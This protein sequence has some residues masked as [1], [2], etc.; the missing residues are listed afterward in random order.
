MIIHFKVEAST[1]LGFGHLRRCEVLAAA[2]AGKGVQCVFLQPDDDAASCENIIVDLFHRDNQENPV[3]LATFLKTLRG[4]AVFIDG[5][6]D[7]A[8]RDQAAPRLLAYV[9]PYPGAEEDAPPNAQHWIKGGQYAILGPQFSGLPPKKIVPRAKNLLLAFGGADPQ[10]LTARVM[11]ALAGT[12]FDIR[13]ILGP[14]F[15]E[16]HKKRI[17]AIGGAFTLIE[18]AADLLPHYLWADIAAGSSG[19]TRFE[20]AA[21]GVP[22]VF[23][24]LYPHHARLSEVYAQSGA[25]QYLGL[26]DKLDAKAWRGALCDL[27]VNE[28]ARKAMSIAGQRLVD[29]RGT[30]RLAEEIL[31]LFNA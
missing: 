21:C 14:L 28:A 4:K 16:A 6:F 23:A 3:A 8:F 24:A 30:Q 2:L 26:Y 29:G 5:M 7:D 9:A 17:R 22:A 11:E 25:A 10:H 15:D 1:H 27:A 12:D 19:L 18:S 31:R 13:V 20:F